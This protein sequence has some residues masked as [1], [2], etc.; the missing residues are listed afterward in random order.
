MKKI[1]KV[2]V[3]FWGTESY[4]EYL[5]E[6][7]AR[8]EKY[9]LPD[10]E[11]QYFVFTDAELDNTPD[12][13][14]LI[15]IPHYGFPETFHKTFEEILK[16]EKLVSD[17]DWLVSVDADLYT[18]EKIDY[19]EFFDDSK[20]YFGVH[21]P[22]H[23]IGMTPHNKSPGSF[24]RNPRSNAYVSD[25]I[26]DMNI[27]WQG[28]L[29]G[30]K[31]PYVFDMIRQIDQ[32]TKEDI[33]RDSVGQYYEESY[34]NKYFLTHKDDVHTLRSDYAYPEL[35]KEYCDFPNKMMHLYKD[36]KSLNNFEW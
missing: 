16:I 14:T 36:N 22:C 8:L 10:M 25:D 13:I 33:P 5:S 15:E 7:Y 3:T 17:Y 31:M 26:I 21:H 9:F 28:C 35:F 27:Y 30:G 29:W 11:K 2:A 32:W 12:N 20:K 6:W 24:D 34:L 19:N 1:S 4:A 23:F 18:Q